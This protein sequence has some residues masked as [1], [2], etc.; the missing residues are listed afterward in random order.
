M[1]KNKSI[2]ARTKHSTT[3]FSSSLNK[4][5]KT[6]P[7][8]KLLKMSF[9]PNLFGAYGLSTIPMSKGIIAVG[10]LE[11]NKIT[12][13]LFPQASK[14]EMNLDGDYALFFLEDE[15][16]TWCKIS[17]PEIIKFME[18]N[19]TLSKM[20]NCVMVWKPLQNFKS[21]YLVDIDAAAKKMSFMFGF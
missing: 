3:S 18:E 17:K 21:T 2:K 4:K 15:N 1:S 13:V 16:D 19:A 12:K 9:G 8:S 11:N 7:M 5:T 20:N 6:Y 14:P 10:F